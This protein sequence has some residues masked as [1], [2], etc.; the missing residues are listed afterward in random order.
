MRT[1]QQA[2]SISL[3]GVLLVSALGISFGLVSGSFAIIFDGMISI[4]DAVISILSIWVARLILRSTTQ[5]LSKRF[6]MGFWH[7]EPLLLA[8]SSLLMMLIAGYAVAQAVSA[9]L[10]GGREMEFGP[11]IIYAVVVMVLTTVFALVEHRANRRIG[12]AL[13]AMDVK[14]W[15]MT[16]G[17]TSALLVAFVVGIFLD[18]TDLEHLTPYVDPLILIIVATVL[19]PLPFSTFRRALSEIGLATPAPLRREVENVAERVT[20]DEGFLS[21]HVY[22]ATVGRSRQVELVFLVPEGLPERPLEDWDAIR[23]E[24]TDELGHGDPNSWITVAF[25]TDPQLV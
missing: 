17:V 16:G 19:I 9:L 13:V 7:L 20:A 12:S 25:T 11:A 24:V 5:G 8:F 18:G 2:L 23:R 15:I 1:E 4:V 3:A 22:T 6:S 14:G 21:S 10:S